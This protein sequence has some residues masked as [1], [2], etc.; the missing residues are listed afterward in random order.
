MIL[1]TYDVN[2][3]PY[4]EFIAQLS[5]N[6]TSGRVCLF[7]EGEIAF[8]RF[9]IELDVLR[10]GLKAVQLDPNRP[11]GV[12]SQASMMLTCLEDLTQEILEQKFAEVQR[13]RLTTAMGIF[14]NP[15]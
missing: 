8:Q 2:G 3:L 1:H 6:L 4:E 5:D 14:V 12:A 11:V 9:D 10:A 13:K 15:A 7:N